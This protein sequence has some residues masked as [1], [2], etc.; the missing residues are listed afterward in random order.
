MRAVGGWVIS[1]TTICPGWA[2]PSPPGGDQ[3]VLTQAPFFGHHQAD[4]LFDGVAADHARATAFQHLDHHALAT[5]ALIQAGFARHD[6]VAVHDGAHGRWRQEQVGAA[7][8]R[9]QEAKSVRM[10]AD[11]AAH[12]FHLARQS[13]ASTAV[14]QQLAVT[15]HRPQ[16]ATEGILVALARDVQGLGQFVEIQ[17]LTAFGQHLQN[18]LARGHGKFVFGRFTL[19]H[20]IGIVSGFTR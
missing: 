12:H 20:G 3:N 15:L 6:D 19:G 17:W 2:L 8:V 4:A 11:P 18:R 16:P 1:T 9:D 5:P 10:A 13:V 14:A 7:V